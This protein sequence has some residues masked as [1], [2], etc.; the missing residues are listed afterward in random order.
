MVFTPPHPPAKGSDAHISER[1]TW[2]EVLLLGMPALLHPHP[3]LQRHV[4][5]CMFKRHY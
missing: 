2:G 3:P 5:L 4:C 1:K